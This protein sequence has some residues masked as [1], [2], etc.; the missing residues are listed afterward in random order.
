MLLISKD[1]FNYFQYSNRLI[2][3]VYR[4]IFSTDEYENL[5]YS[6]HKG[7]SLER[8]LYSSSRIK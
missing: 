7:I 1:F 3:D 6:E 2:E 8:L 4:S 5:S